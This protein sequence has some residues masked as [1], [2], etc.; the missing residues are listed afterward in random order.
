[1]RLLAAV[2]FLVRAVEAACRYIYRR[3]SSLVKERA[4]VTVGLYL[5]IP[6]TLHAR[7]KGAAASRE[8]TLRQFAQRA[9]WNELQRLGAGRGVADAIRKRSRGFG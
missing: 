5:R 4:D 6:P 8:E 9:L 7:V 3:R 2:S 1:M